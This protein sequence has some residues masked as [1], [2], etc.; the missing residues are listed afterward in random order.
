MNMTSL[1]KTLLK[2]TVA[3]AVIVSLL[4][5]SACA[6]ESDK[7]AQNAERTSVTLEKPVPSK[8]VENPS[9]EHRAVAKPSKKSKFKIDWQAVLKDP[10]QY[11][12]IAS[13][14]P[15]PYEPRTL[16][17]SERG[18]AIQD[19][20][21]AGIGVSNLPCECDGA[22]GRVGNQDDQ[23][24][25][26][27]AAHG[28][29]SLT[30][31]VINT[32]NPKQAVSQWEVKNQECPSFLSKENGVTSKV[33]ITPLNVTERAGRKVAGYKIVTI[34]KNFHGSMRQEQILFV[35]PLDNV[36]VE[37]MGMSFNQ[38]ADQVET[39]ALLD[40]ALE[41]ADKLEN[42][43]LPPDQLAQEDK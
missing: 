18:Q 30:L 29:N 36:V 12:L 37:V 24:A 22:G 33:F 28:N 15:Q 10:A 5:F 35:V 21:R 6:N 40:R 32:A 27:I 20:G 43:K 25:M 13:G 26:Q 31:V 39:L 2:T 17:L 7:S 14:F 3:G 19:V 16:T 1:P 34:T 42:K 23:L 4:G 11:L 41:R 38:E 8:N 9:G